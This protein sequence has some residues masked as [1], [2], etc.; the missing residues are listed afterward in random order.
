MLYVVYVGVMHTPHYEFVSMGRTEEEAQENMARGFTAH[1][2][3]TCPGETTTEAE[4]EHWMRRAGYENE[5]PS[6]QEFAS[7][8]SD[9]YGINVMR[10]DRYE[11]VMCDGAK[12]PD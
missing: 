6:L 12:I 2:V 11:D 9:Y 10:F 1:L 7:L 8:L 5:D 4:Q 3:R